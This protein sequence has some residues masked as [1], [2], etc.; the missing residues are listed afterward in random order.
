MKKEGNA[1][2]SVIQITMFQLQCVKGRWDGEL[3][4]S[5]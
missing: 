2:R 5:L 1:I 4:S 3:W